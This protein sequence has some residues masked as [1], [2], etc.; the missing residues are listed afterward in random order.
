MADE[1][2]A[3]LD[4]PPPSTPTGM[5]P[6]ESPLDKF[7]DKPPVKE[8][9]PEG[10]QIDKPQTVQLPS[11]PDA[12]E[13]KGK[14][15]PKPEDKNPEE[16]K[17]EK[18]EARPAEKAEEV[19]TGK[20]APKALR[21]A[22]DKLK[23]EM[24][25]RE[26]KYA[27]EL[28][29]VRKSTAPKDDPEKAELAKRYEELE[30]RHKALDEQMRYVD[31]TKSEAFQKEHY[32]PYV[33][34]YQDAA[35]RVLAWRA[36]ND[37]GT[38]R[39]TTAKDFEKLLSITNDDEAEAFAAKLFG[40]DVKAARAITIRDEI[41]SAEKNMR[42][43]AEEYR[44]NGIAREQEHAK[45]REQREK[46]EYEQSLAQWENLNKGA[47][48]KYPEW[49]TAAED[50]EK[51]AEFLRVGYENVDKALGAENGM[52]REEVLAR[53]AAV[54]NQ[55]GA[56]RYMV[57]KWETEKALRIER[58][59]ELA[60]FKESQPKPGAAKGDKAGA[61]DDE[62]PALLRDVE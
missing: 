46:Q 5:E 11:K 48:E 9:K 8:A 15:A 17:P 61:D 32:Q 1:T 57:H 54:R 38:T 3:V 14:A 27:T 16:K 34:K 53:R 35:A 47:Q 52:P 2:T 49:F 13:E 24:K 41:V 25:E 29:T 40:S 18:A 50:D 31:Y 43:V 39:E 19:D 37:D 21:E 20:M 6:M 28:D 26:A 10:T 4:A 56:F 55:A 12:K 30:K 33:E 45:A 23:R 59:K 44:K 51:G 42:K 36:F 62:L 58:E 22:Y 60:E 7:D